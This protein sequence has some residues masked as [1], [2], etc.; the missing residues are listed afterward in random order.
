MGDSNRTNNT[1][2]GQV[3]GGHYDEEPDP[4]TLQLQGD[5]TITA[6]DLQQQQQQ[7]NQP[8]KSWFGAIRNSHR[9]SGERHHSANKQLPLDSAN[10]HEGTKRTSTST[11]PKFGFRRTSKSK[12]QQEATTSLS[13]KI[14]R[15][16]STGKS[17]KGA[18]HFPKGI[19]RNLFRTPRQ[20]RYFPTDRLEKSRHL[21]FAVH[22]NGT[23]SIRH[24]S[25]P[26]P[27]LH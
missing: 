16:W 4:S 9:D 23:P 6:L 20:R 18:L 2:F 1:H 21:S 19:P 22:P 17:P 14:R 24:P 27:P 13:A 5:G 7:Q 26:P 15:L 11:T 8:K 12:P 3:S 25:T 10:K